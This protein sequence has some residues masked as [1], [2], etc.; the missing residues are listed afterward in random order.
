MSDEQSR[1][2]GS[3]RKCLLL[4]GDDMMDTRLE[5]SENPRGTGAAKKHGMCHNA[6]TANKSGNENLQQASCLLTFTWEDAVHL[7]AT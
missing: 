3:R 6:I 4:V 2:Q 5:V 1:E 7:L